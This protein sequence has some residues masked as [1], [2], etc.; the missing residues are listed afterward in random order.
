M[1]L[2]TGNLYYDY[3]YYDYYYNLINNIF[4]S[5]KSHFEK[6]GEVASVNIMKR[7]TG[8]PRGFAFVTM[9]DP[10]ARDIVL[11]QEVH[12]ID[13][14]V[15]DVKIAVPQTEVNVPTK[16]DSR[17][18]FVGRLPP[19][20]TEKDFS[21]YFS[22]FGPVKDVIIMVDHANSKSRGFGFVTF[23]ND[24]CVDA[25]LAQENEI[26]GKWVDVKRAEPKHNQL[27]DR[28]GR[29]GGGRGGY[30][31]GGGYDN[32]GRGGSGYGRGG[33]DN[34]GSYDMGGRGIF[35]IFIYIL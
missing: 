8:Q 21:D 16:T 28:G 12:T 7:H 1:Q 3:Y 20:V 18:I 9:K 30:G 17:K 5:L 13:G 10:A 15:A 27:N 22:R 32:Y 11:S 29:G 34:Y 6:F 14:K 31:R 26:M 33:Y 24:G 35:I 4:I 25:A 19:E 23:E 2:L